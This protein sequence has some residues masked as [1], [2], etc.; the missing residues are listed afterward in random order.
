MNAADQRKN[1]DNSSD[2]SLG[3]SDLIEAARQVFQRPKSNNLQKDLI[4]SDMHE[5][6]QRVK[7]QN[8]QNSNNKQSNKR[9]LVNSGINNSNIPKPSQNRMAAPSFGMKAQ[10][11]MQQ[12]DDL[13]EE[14]F[15]D[16]DNIDEPRVVQ[17]RGGK[18][19]AH[20]SD[21]LEEPMDRS[22]DYGQKP[23]LSKKQT[24]HQQQ[25]MFSPKFGGGAGESG[26][27]N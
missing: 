14:D 10:Q 24:S 15:D 8:Q 9:K 5:A 1:A 11:P 23:N 21:D 22:A 20:D 13:C 6:I 16:N 2:D 25:Q 27:D 19:A 3:Q 4:Q 12:D 18:F 17:R 26:L 7:S